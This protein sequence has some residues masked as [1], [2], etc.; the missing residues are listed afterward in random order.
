LPFP[1]FSFGCFYAAL[2]FTSPHFRTHQ[3]P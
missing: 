1:H 2:G 3:P